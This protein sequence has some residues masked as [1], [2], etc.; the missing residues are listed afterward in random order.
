MK[1]KSAPQGDVMPRQEAAL[2]L[3]R[4]LSTNEVLLRAL[5]QTMDVVHVQ[6][7]VIQ[8]LHE[9]ARADAP[10]GHPSEALEQ[11]ERGLSA[12]LQAKLADLREQLAPILDMVDESCR[13]LEGML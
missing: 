1:R 10:N 9:R 3:G 13:A 8:A 7:Q 4:S 2:W 5:L 6:Q 12:E 11:M